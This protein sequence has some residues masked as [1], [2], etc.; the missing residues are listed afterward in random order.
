MPGPRTNA[1]FYA[2]PVSEFLAASNEEAYAPLAAAKG[3]TLAPEQQSAWRLQLPVLRAALEELVAP[4]SGKRDAA[5][6]L[7]WL[8]A[9]DGIPRKELRP[10]FPVSL[11]RFAD[12]E[13]SHRVRPFAGHGSA[14]P[15]TGRPSCDPRR[16]PLTAAELQR[17]IRG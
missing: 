5:L 4:R 11:R 15:S 13:L 1:A 3:Y 2:A 16:T 12:D 17:A 14:H 8:R 6:F 10:L 9:A 7:G